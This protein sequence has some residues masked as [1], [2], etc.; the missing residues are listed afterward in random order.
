MIALIHFGELQEVGRFVRIFR[1]LSRQLAEDAS[2]IF[3]ESRA[4]SASETVN[5]LA[6]SFCMPVSA[7]FTADGAIM[8]RKPWRL[9]ANPFL[10]RALVKEFFSDDPLNTGIM[11]LMSANERFQL[12]YCAREL[13]PFT[14]GV[15]RFVEIGSF[16]GGTFFEIAWAFERNAKEFQGIAIEPYGNPLFSE[17]IKMFGDRALHLKMNSHDAAPI[18]ANMFEDDKRPVL[19]LID[20]DHRYEAVCQDIMDYYPVLAPGG[21]IIFHD[22]LPPAEEL[23]RKYVESGFTSDNED[24]RRACLELMEGHFGLE[25]IELPLLYPGS[26]EQTMGYKPII[27]GV[28]STIRAYRKPLVSDGGP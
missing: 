24:I 1:M 14:K 8:L 11:T 7:C 3:S 27:P 13:V 12:Y 21:I 19:I 5:S 9:A 20:G 2:I 28:Y 25:P 4:V 16:A 17:V 10:S 26:L 18:L 15:T 6:D 23:P 22:F